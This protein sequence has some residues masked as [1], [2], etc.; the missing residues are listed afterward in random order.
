MLDFKTKKYLSNGHHASYKN[1]VVR[2]GTLKFMGR[3]VHQYIE[4]S[5]RDDLY[6]LC[7]LMLH[8]LNGNLP[9]Q[10]VRGTRREK[11]EKILEMKM[12]YT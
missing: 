9:W 11:H 2:V 1:R 3:N 6:S 4:A 5:R 7:Y 10:G 8:L 12:E